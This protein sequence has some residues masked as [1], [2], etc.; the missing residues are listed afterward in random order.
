M[1]ILLLTHYYAPEYGAPQRR[2]SALVGRFVR[3]G[4]QVT[5]A[6]PVPHYPAGRPRP[7]QAAAH[8]VGAVERGVHGETILRVAWLPHRSDILTRTVDHLAAALDTAR[9]VSVRFAWREH[10]PD[11]VISTAPAIPSLMLGAALARLWGVPHVAEMRD[12][13]PDLVTHVGAKAAV[14]SE[15]AHAAAPSLPRRALGL[16]IGMAK[17]RVHGLVTAWQRDAAAVV[18]TTSRFAEVLRDRGVREVQVVRN[19]V[20]LGVVELASDPP[21]GGHE[22]LRCLYLGN[23][24]RSQGLGTVVQAAARLSAEGVPLEV[25]LI[26]HGVEGEDLAALAAELDAPVTVHGRIPHSSVAAHYDWADT[27][28]VSLKDWEPF[29]WTIPSKLYELLAV[30]KHV[31]ALLAGEAA[32][33]VREADAGDVLPPE[34]VEA[35][36]GLWRDLAVDRSRCRVS[37]SGRDWVASHADDELLAHRYLRILETIT[38]QNGSLT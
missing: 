34:D 22:E 32:A 24:G 19:G 13:W 29:S 36:M 28:I 30:G 27:V 2:W 33:V 11:V 8:P 7:E 6:A 25:R 15:I 31:T 17:K 12:A 1:R 21:A 4:H 3:A 18:T 20:D 9:R 16:A 5:V 14:P 23:M 35:L 38:A 26:G 10:R 37:R